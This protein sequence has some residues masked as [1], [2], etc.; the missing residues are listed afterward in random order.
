TALYQSIAAKDSSKL[1]DAG[2]QALSADQYYTVVLRSQNSGAQ[3][4][5]A[6][7]RCRLNGEKKVDETFVLHETDSGVFRVDYDAGKGSNCLKGSLDD[8]PTFVTKALVKRRV[9]G[10]TPQLAVAASIDA[11][12]GKEKVPEP[13]KGFLAKYWYYLVPLVLLLLLGGEESQQEGNSRQIE[14]EL[15]ETRT[16][17]PVVVYD[18]PFGS[19][20]RAAIDDIDGLMLVTVTDADHVAIFREALPEFHEPQFE[21]A[22]IDKC[23]DAFDDTKQLQ[24]GT[25]NVVTLFFGAM[26]VVQFRVG[27]YYGTIVS[28]DICNMG[29][30]HNLVARIRECLKVLSGVTD[31]KASHKGQQP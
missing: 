19:M 20:L 11:S 24:A 15:M 3:Y 7:R 17:S 9:Q 5:L 12:T 30:I 27:T 10:P 26:R 25:R 2:K 13:E 18:G 8:V 22:L 29:M 1:V 16:P 31:D 21:E 23:F 6:A 28:D 4:A 14:R